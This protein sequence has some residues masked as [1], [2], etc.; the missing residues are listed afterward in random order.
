VYVTVKAD[1][2]KIKRKKH[3]QVQP[4]EM[5]QVPLTPKEMI[6]DRAIPAQIEVLIE[7]EV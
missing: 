7:Q 3:R 6:G 5:V 1:G 2:H 4:S